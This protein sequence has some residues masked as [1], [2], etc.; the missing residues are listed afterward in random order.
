M[1]TVTV[2]SSGLSRAARSLSAMRASCSL[3]CGG[4]SPA[5]PL[6]SDLLP[7]TVG[8][9]LPAAE[10]ALVMAWLT[11]T[12]QRWQRQRTADVVR[13][14]LSSSC[15]RAT[16]AAFRKRHKAMR[17]YCRHR[18]QQVDWDSHT[19]Q[20][21]SAVYAHPLLLLSERVSMICL[22]QAFLSAKLHKAIYTSIVVIVPLFSAARGRSRASRL[23]SRGFSQR[24]A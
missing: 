20:I 19:Q 11:S 23:M 3:I 12:A 6:L 9:W 4:V 14:P 17:Q 1:R 5:M 18:G 15:M 8:W 16:A 21:D 24:H 22:D 13:A 7:S 2:T 10:S